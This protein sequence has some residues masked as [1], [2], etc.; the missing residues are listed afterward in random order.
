MKTQ[1]QNEFILLRANGATFD[2]IA[3]ELKVSKATLI[4]WGKLFQEDIQAL[5]FETFLQIKELYGFNQKKRYE[6]LLKQLDLID[7]GILQTD[8]QKATLKD[9][10]LCKNDIL[11]QIEAIEKRISVD[12]KVTSTDEYGITENL[13]LKLN[14]A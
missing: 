2:A 13:R 12:V 4:Q 11:S 14:E 1:K 9:L 7:N 3:K 5:Q 8:L 6:T 10:I